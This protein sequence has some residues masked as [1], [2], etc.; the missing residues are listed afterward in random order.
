MGKA[1]YMS[2]EQSEYKETDRRSD[3]FS[4]GI[5][6]YQLLTGRSVF[7]DD[8][9]MIT[10]R[11]VGRA[12]VPPVRQY[13]PEVPPELEQILEKALQRK[14]E[15][16]YQN[17]G[18]M[19]YELEYYMYHDRFGPTNLTLEKYLTDLFP[20]RDFHKHQVDIDTSPTL[21]VEMGTEGVLL[22]QEN[23]FE[24]P[25]PDDVETDTDLGT[26]SD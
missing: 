26:N 2:P 7:E 18:E 13:N 10:L 1:Q 21:A 24:K 5:V 3:I 8:N 20:E 19:G 14:P 23:P 11:N 4:L 6:F 15:N 22:V 16:R 17:A 12:K 9:T 25:N